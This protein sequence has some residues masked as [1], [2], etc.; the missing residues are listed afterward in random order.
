MGFEL[1]LAC[2]FRLATPSTL[3]ALPEQLGRIPGSALRVCRFRA[4]GHRDA[5]PSQ[6]R[7]PDWCSDRVCAAEL[8]APPTL[9]AAYSLPTHGQ[10][11]LNDAR[12]ACLEV[13]IPDF[14][15]FAPGSDFQEGVE[16]FMTSAVRR[17][18]FPGFPDRFNRN[19]E[20]I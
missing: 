5:Q 16:A 14:R 3:Y 17:H 20:H 19:G 8:E 15:P 2:D 4:R 18:S 6:A 9:L 13:A 1:S 11:L 7:R 12:L 10:K